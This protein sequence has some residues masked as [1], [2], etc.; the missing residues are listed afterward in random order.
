VLWDLCCSG[1]VAFWDIHEQAD[2]E[3]CDIGDHIVARHALRAE[4]QQ[5]V[6]AALIRSLNTWWEFFEDIARRS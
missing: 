4:W 6:R 2:R 5:R 3:H 1:F